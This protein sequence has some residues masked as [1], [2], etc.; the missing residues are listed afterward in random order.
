M[1]HIIISSVS[2]KHLPYLYIIS[3]K[4]MFSKE[5]RYY[6]KC[7]YAFCKVPV[8]IVEFERDLI[9]LKEFREIVKYKIKFIVPR[10]DS[11]LLQSKRLK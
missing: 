11:E 8:M 4:A 9:F 7:K 3:N 6:D 1:H 2:C 5:T 10:V